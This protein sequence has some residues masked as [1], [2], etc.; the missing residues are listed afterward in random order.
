MKLDTVGQGPALIYLHDWGFQ[1]DV[2]RRQV[3]FFRGRYRN[4][5]I[6]YTLEP[7]PADLTHETLLERICEE[8]SARLDAADRTPR[9]ILAHGF[10]AYLAYELIQRGI[11]PGA[12][13]LLGGYARFTNGEGYL[14]GQAPERVAELRKELQADERQMLRHYHQLALSPSEV[15]S[16]EAQLPVPYE[17]ADFLKIAFDTLASHDYVDVLADLPCKAL[18][19]QG[20]EDRLCPVWQGELLRK[21]LRQSV[22][23]LCRGAGHVPFVTQYAQVN[24][25]IEQFLEEGA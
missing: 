9:A 23:Y 12:L 19:V 20:E 1:A 7:V 11:E 3:E 2:W 21:R 5:V 13:V 16:P 14:S 24:R 4:V 18:V 22:F 8:L 25:R 17:S 15:N 6:D 10:G